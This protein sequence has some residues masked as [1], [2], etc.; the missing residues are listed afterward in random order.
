[1]KQEDGLM[2]GEDRGLKPN[3]RTDPPLAFIAGWFIG[4]GCGVLATFLAQAVLS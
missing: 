4:V 3:E 1:M 2:M